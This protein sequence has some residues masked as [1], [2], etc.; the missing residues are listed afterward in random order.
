MKLPNANFVIVDPTKVKD[1]LLNA[2]HRHG[3]SKA[4]F[5]GRFGFTVTNWEKLAMALREHAQQYEVIE[6]VET[7]FGS[8]Y[9]VEG[10]LRT[11]DG[12]APRV[13][14]VWQLDPGM[15]APRLITAYPSR[16]N[17]D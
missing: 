12:R 10:E 3:R 2:G 6:V 11:P 8:R 14:S 5:F 13:R 4:R 9:E 1:Y 7:E 15:V 16:K 17:H